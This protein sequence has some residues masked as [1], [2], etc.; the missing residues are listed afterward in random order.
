MLRVRA[1]EHDAFARAHA[2]RAL[3]HF[4]REFARDD[5]ADM[6]L[7][8]PVVL[9]EAAAEFEQTQ[10]YAASADGLEAHFG[11]R[12]LPGHGLELRAHLA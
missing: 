1:G 8:A 11:R 10:L 5:I 12:R 3:G 9:D 2:H 7:A 4:E 6:L